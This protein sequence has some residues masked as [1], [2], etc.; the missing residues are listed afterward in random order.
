M[1][2]SVDPCWPVAV[3]AVMF[4]LSLKLVLKGGLWSPFLNALKCRCFRSSSWI[5]PARSRQATLLCWIATLLTLPASSVRSLRRS[6]AALARSWRT[7][8]SLSSLETPA[9]LYWRLQNPC[10]LKASLTIHHWVS[11]M[12]SLLHLHQLLATARFVMKTVG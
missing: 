4:I 7:T 12:L 5:I 11:K 8:R 10:V 6:T 3:T 9:L 2:T 1:W